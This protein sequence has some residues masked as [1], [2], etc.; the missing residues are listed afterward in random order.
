MNGDADE[1]VAKR[2]VKVMENLRCLRKKYLKKRNFVCA[3]HSAPAKTPAEF[4]SICLVARVRLLI[5]HRH[6]LH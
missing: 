2:V 6:Q 4:C 1:P 3:D 5:A